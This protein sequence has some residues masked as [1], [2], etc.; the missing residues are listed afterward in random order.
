MGRRSTTG[1]VRPHGAGIQLRFTWRAREWRPTL[2]LAPTPANLKHA[3]RLLADAKAAIAAGTFDY[4]KWFPDARNAP[5]GA[6]PA[7]FGAYAKLWHASLTDYAPST[8]QD[9]QQI[10]D[11]AWLPKLKDKPISAIRYSTLVEIL[12]ELGVTGKTRNNTLIPLQI[13]RAHV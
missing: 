3:A 7:T 12:G 9:Y 4:G 10:L 1:G 2:R 5:P 13:G 6:L 8:K 11:R